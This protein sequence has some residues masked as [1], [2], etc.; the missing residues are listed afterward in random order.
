[1]QSYLFLSACRTVEDV[2]SGDVCFLRGDMITFYST[3]KFLLLTFGLESHQTAGWLI[4]WLIESK[5]I[6]NK[7]DRL[8]LLKS[9]NSCRSW[10]LS[11][12]HIWSYFNLIQTQDDR[13]SLWVF[14]FVGQLFNRTMILDASSIFYITAQ[15]E[16]VNIYYEQSDKSKLLLYF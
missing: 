4:D 1:M 12:S 13:R 9:R 11:D 15:D 6:C 10:E 7:F 16:F 3:N 2:R 5:I 14:V 8:K